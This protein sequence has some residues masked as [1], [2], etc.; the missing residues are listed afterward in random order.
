MA[1]NYKNST[2]GTNFNAGTKRKLYYK[3]TYSKNRR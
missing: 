3:E 1:I 2:V